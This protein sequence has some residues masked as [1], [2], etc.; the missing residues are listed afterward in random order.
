MAIKTDADKF[1]SLPHKSL[2]GH[3]KKLFQR[4]S[5]TQL[6]NHFYSN[7]VVKHWNQLP[8]QVVTAPTVASF[9]KNLR[10][11]PIGMKD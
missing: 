7:R 3:S 11:L 1:F 2:R 4:R 9:K 8:D 5:R 10:V 6:A